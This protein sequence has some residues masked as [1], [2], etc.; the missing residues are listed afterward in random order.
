M[1]LAA[2]RGHSRIV[3]FLATQANAKIDAVGI[4]GFRP[5]DNS[6]ILGNHEVTTELIHLEPQLK[7]PSDGQ[8]SPLVLAAQNENDRCVELLLGDAKADK[9]ISSRLNIDFALFYA[10]YCENITTCRTLLDYGANL[11]AINYGYSP[12]TIAVRNGNEE[13]VKLLLDRRPHP[14]VNLKDKALYIAVHMKNTALIRLL[15][16]NDCDPDVAVDGPYVALHSAATD[17]EIVKMLVG[18]IGDFEVRTPQ[19][20]TALMLAAER[21]EE[22]ARILIEHKADVNAKVPLDNEFWEGWTPIF[23]AANA[24]QPTTVALLV[25]AGADL[26]HKAKDGTSALH[27]AVDGDAL[28]A[29]MEFNSQ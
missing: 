15:I 13:I 4:G 25:E 17:S 18:H 12:L 8:I 6:C 1:A 7:L 9:D 20:L 29:L 21:N 14:D 2:V 3:R 19:N 24:N 22:S 11:D 16:D 27:L 28:S 5:I 26:K 23:F 10:A